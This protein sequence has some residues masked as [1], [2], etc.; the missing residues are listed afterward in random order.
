[1]GP[2]EAGGHDPLRAG[3][4]RSIRRRDNTIDPDRWRAAAAAG[5]LIGECRLR[6]CGGYMVPDDPPPEPGSPTEFTARCLVCRRE[7]VAPGGRVLARSGRHAEAPEFWA[8]RA[9][10]LRRGGGGP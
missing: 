6:G 8:R 10:M 7:V 2:V 5:D 3:L 1:M 9:E 4:Y